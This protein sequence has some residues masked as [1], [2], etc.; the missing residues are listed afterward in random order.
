MS[1]ALT[2]EPIQLPGEVQR[3]L[4]GDRKLLEAGAGELVTRFPVT[5][6]SLP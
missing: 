2:C 5:V 6:Q 3:L 1:L 4:V